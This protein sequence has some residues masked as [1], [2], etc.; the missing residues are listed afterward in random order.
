[1]D[2]FQQSVRVKF[3]GITNNE[4]AQRAV[5]L[6][7]DALGFVFAPSP[8]QVTA[9]QVRT[10]IKALPPF[11]VNVGVFVDETEKTIRAVAEYCGLQMIQFHGQESPAFCR[12]F[13]PGSIKSFRLQDASSLVPIGAY[14]GQVK[15]LHLDSFQPGK[16]GGSGRTFPWELAVQAKGFSLPIILSG[17]LTPDNLQ[18][19]IMQVKPYGVD[20]SSGIED[21]P[22]K[23][24]PALMKQVIDI[25]KRP[26][27]KSSSHSGAPRYKG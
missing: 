18:S 13:W 14:L 27:F 3:C 24:N 9:E 17:G 2:V 4:D 21:R 10:I 15:A 26:P 12:R 6:G 1:M 20:I 22:G 23:K 5:E 11:V 16:L 8:R 7:V 25:V 19:A